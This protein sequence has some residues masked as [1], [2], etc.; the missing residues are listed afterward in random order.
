MKPFD[1]L[2]QA[3]SS[4]RC[5]EFRLVFNLA[6]RYA[7]CMKRLIF[8]VLRVGLFAVLLS[9]SSVFAGNTATNPVPRDAKWVKR[10]E[11]FVEEA[12]AKKGEVD[13][14]FIGDSITDGWR[15]KGKAVWEKYYA[16]RHALNLGIGGDRT[17][18]VLWRL[19][20]GEV[21][22]LK[23]KAVVLLIGINN[24]PNHTNGLPT[25]TVAEIVAGVTAVV[26]EIQT[27]L[28]KS[29]VLLLA[30][31]PYKQKG[32]PMRDKVAKINEGIAKLGKMK[33]VTFLDISQKFLEPDGTL[34]TE[35]MPD[36]LHPNAKGY[37]IWADA[38][39]PTLDKLLK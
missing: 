31:F 11:G 24:T 32:D 26:K 17:E 4:H 37:Q 19:Q 21:A 22:G 6:N 16:P 14:L 12:K 28:P 10:H 7:E 23:P 5:F 18:H 8:P 35:I 2:G 39:D 1:R 3:A 34:S 15:S 9:T 30:V 25:N 36:L 38:M 33:R 13:L 29:E 27:Q 20:N